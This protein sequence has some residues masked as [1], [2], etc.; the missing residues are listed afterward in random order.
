[1]TTLIF[2]LMMMTP[3]ALYS[4]CYSTEPV[5]TATT[6]SRVPGTASIVVLARPAWT[7]DQQELAH[8]LGEAPIVLVELG[9]ASSSSL[10][11]KLWRH[12]V[13]TECLIL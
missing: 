12:C 1:V 5:S 6:G 13:D 2:L 7:P 4:E 3:V 10:T 8:E 9:Y 11:R